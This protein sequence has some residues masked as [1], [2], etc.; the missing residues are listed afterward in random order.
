MRA[1]LRCY[2]AIGANS[3]CGEKLVAWGHFSRRRD[4]GRGPAAAESTRAR[5]E[6]GV[7]ELGFLDACDIEQSPALAFIAHPPDHAGRLPDKQAETSPAGA[8]ERVRVHHA[9]NP[10]VAEVQDATR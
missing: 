1:C 9:P 3:H 5:N 7:Q 10:V 8:T 6:G 2:A 4:D